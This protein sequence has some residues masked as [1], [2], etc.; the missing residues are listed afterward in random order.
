MFIARMEGTLM[1]LAEAPETRFRYVIWFDYTRQAINEIQEGTL[2]A[3]P[4]FASS[5]DTRR[6][7]VLEVAT[8]LPTHYALQGGSG[9]YP[10]FVVEA[11][12]SASEDWETQ[13]KEATEDTFPR[14]FW[15][16]SSFSRP[17]I[18]ASAT[19]SY[20]AIENISVT[21]MLIPAPIRLSIA[22]IPALV[23]GILIITLGRFSMEKYFLA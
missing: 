17:F 15:E 19:D 20:C 5:G 14:F 16:E 10:G 8:I 4:N 2:L 11:A 1:E 22:G 3:A 9:G 23:A 7:S 18:Y 6:Y 21:L 13:E 12:R